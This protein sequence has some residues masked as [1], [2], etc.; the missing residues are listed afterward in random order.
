MTDIEAAKEALIW[1]SIVAFWV[2]VAVLVA[3]L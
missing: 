2:G 1:F 3:A